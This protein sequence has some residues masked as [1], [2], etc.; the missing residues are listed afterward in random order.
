MLKRIS[1]F[2]VRETPAIVI[3]AGLIAYFFPLSFSWVHGLTQT[4]ILGLIMLTMGLTLTT[5]DF[6][7]LANS[8]LDLVIGAAAQ[9]TIM[10][11][12][13][14][15]LVKL[16]GLNEGIAVGLIL[17]GCSPGGVSSNLMSFLCKGDVAYSVG[18]T[19]VSTLLSP[20]MTPLLMLY[21]AGTRVEVDALGMF[22]SIIFVTILPIVLGVAANRFMGEN[23]RYLEVKSV[24]PLVAVLALAAIVGGVVSAQGSAIAK[25]GLMIFIAVLIHNGLGYL[26]GFFAALLFRFAA[27]KRR[28]LSLEVG[29]QNAGLAVV[30][31]TKHFPLLPEAAIASAVSCIWH[32]ISGA[33]MSR[34]FAQR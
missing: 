8:P 18:M 13:A 26:L 32:S 4:L 30:L 14:V 20:I 3:V 31:A 15:L 10:P 9:F 27:P 19:T 22:Q 33:L 17:V 23:K 29:M 21:L 12:V 25:S 28:T 24:L 16:L 34:F 2:V 1:D 7:A 5:E 11:L 6:R